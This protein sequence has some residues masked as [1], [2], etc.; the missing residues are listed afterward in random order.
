[1]NRFIIRYAGKY[2]VRVVSNVAGRVFDLTSEERASRFPNA[3]EARQKAVEH[4]IKNFT[5]EPERSLTGK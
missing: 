3:A 5:V 2:P 4:G 1:M